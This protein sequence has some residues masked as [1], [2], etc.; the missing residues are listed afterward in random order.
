M[1]SDKRTDSYHKIHLFVRPN[2]K[3]SK[4]FAIAWVLT[5]WARQ[6]TIT[7]CLSSSLY[8]SN[9]NQSN[10]IDRNAYFLRSVSV[11]FFPID[12]FDINFQ[13][14]HTKKLV[15]LGW[16]FNLITEALWQLWTIWVSFFRVC[17][18]FDV[19]FLNNCLIIISSM[20]RP[21]FNLLRI[22]WKLL[23]MSINCDMCI[24][25]QAHDDRFIG[26]FT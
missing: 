20:F 7:F 8:N 12:A 9:S 5:S 25:C 18:R 2:E 24:T 14:K 22:G 26:S 4:Y 23:G 17:K 15:L 16:W 19:C 6:L 13:L 21:P 1:A 11:I 3:K 10:H